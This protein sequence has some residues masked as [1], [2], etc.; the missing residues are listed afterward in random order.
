VLRKKNG[1]RRKIKKR[2]QH[3]VGHTKLTKH[4]PRIVVQKVLSSKSGRMNCPQSSG[5]LGHYN[6]MWVA[7]ATLTC[8]AVSIPA[9]RKKGGIGW[10]EAAARTNAHRGCILCGVEG[11]ETNSTRTISTGKNPHQKRYGGEGFARMFRI[12]NGCQLV[13]KDGST[14]RN[15]ADLKTAN[16]TIMEKEST[17]GAPGVAGTFRT[18]NNVCW[19]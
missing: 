19:G 14:H 3:Q 2:P 1:N 8:A 9:R 17:D 7:L 11:K 15:P 5:R 16:K 10:R 12:A 13:G 4:L 18:F 6:K